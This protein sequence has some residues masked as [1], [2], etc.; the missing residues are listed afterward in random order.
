MGMGSGGG[1][2]YIVGEK[3]LWL[4]RGCA[5]KARLRKEEAVK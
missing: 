1:G 4:L 5:E 2:G 3:G